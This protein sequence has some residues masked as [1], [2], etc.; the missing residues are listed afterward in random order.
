M[1]K[2]D[3]EVA[4]LVRVERAPSTLRSV[5]LLAEDDDAYYQVAE[6]WASDR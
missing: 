6:T 3:R 4:R 1:T 5:T 2:H